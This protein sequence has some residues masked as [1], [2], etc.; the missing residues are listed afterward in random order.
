MYSN[1]EMNFARTKKLCECCQK[2]FSVTKPKN[3]CLMLTLSQ[4]EINHESLSN[5]CWMILAKYSIYAVM[6]YVL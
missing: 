4:M 1:N 5:R 6:Y 3:E 2:R